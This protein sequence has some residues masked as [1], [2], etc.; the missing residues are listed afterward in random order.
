MQV[1]AQSA[2]LWTIAGVVIVLL[3]IMRR[4]RNRAKLVRL[5]DDELP[6]EPA[7]WRE[8]YIENGDDDAS[9]PPPDPAPGG[10]GPTA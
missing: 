4:R 5:Q 10:R 6:D 7:F 3:Y 2:F 1:L 8:D 9:D